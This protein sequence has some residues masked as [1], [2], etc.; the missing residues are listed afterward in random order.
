EPSS[1]VSF[2]SVSEN[3]V[4]S[5]T[6]SK[7]PPPLAYFSSNV[8]EG[9]APLAV[10]FQDQSRGEV[11]AVHWDFG[12]GT[13]S[14]DASPVHVYEMAGTYTVILDVCGGGGCNTSHKDDFI[15]VRLRDPLVANFSANVTS[16]QV[17]LTVQFTDLSNGNPDSWTWDFGDGTFSADP[18]PVHV[19]EN[20]GLYT[21]RLA[22]ANEHSSATFEEVDMVNA[23]HAAIGGSIGYIMIQC[24]LEGA[25]IYLDNVL[26]GTIQNGTLTVPVY[27]TGTPFNTI[28]VKDGGFLLYSGPVKAYPSENQTVIL[29]IP[30]INT[31]SLNTTAPRFQVPNLLGNAT[32]SLPS[33]MKQ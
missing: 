20:P 33:M 21:V 9:Y 31:R 16:G 17:P 25:Q 28:R 10:E 32:A 29:V 5:G 8:T 23:T 30:S 22:V 4:L 14:E 19:Y 13:A 15:S 3:H 7:I 11:S 12:D 24:D 27:V 6:F 2:A 26:Q 18:S 1:V